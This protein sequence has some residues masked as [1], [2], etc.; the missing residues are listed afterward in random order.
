MVCDRPNKAIKNSTGESAPSKRLSKEKSCSICCK[1]FA[2]PQDLRR[3]LISHD[4][5]SSFLCEECGKSYRSSNGLNY[6][7]AL[8][9]PNLIL[10][11]ANPES[12][13]SDQFTCPECS[14]TFGCQIQLKVHFKN[15]HRRAKATYTCTICVQ[16]KD[17]ERKDVFKKH[18]A[19]HERP[20]AF[21]CLICARSF[22]SRSNL[23]CHTRTFHDNSVSLQCPTCSKKFYSKKKLNSHVSEC[24]ARKCCT[25]CKFFCQREE[26]LTEH[27]KK[28]HPADY[29]IQEVFGHNLEG[30]G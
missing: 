14:K 10:D 1:S 15:S 22:S 8:N 12:G 13:N 19:L 18:L 2:R 23:T 29:A 6:H 30:L 9:H 21:T 4:E 3:H 7:K 24:L 27:M 26:E 5:T 25:S 11:L 28:A 20:K 16:P 17:F